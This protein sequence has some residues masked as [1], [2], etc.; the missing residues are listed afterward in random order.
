MQ[1]LEK[2]QIERW[3]MLMNDKPSQNWKDSVQS[4]IEFGKYL[5][6]RKAALSKEEYRAMLRADF[7][8]DKASGEKLSN[9][10]EHP[11]LSNPEY[12]DKLP[13]SWAQLYELR[14]LPDDVLLNAIKSGSLRHTTKYQI[15]ALRGVKINENRASNRV[16][17]D[18]NQELISYVR[19][20]IKLANYSSEESSN[21][22]LTQVADGLGVGHHSFRMLRNIIIVSDREDL[23]QEDRN[24]INDVIRKVNKTRNV[25]TYYPEIK[26]IIDKIWGSNR[27]HTLTDKNAKKRVETFQNGVLILCETCD[28]IMELDQPHMADADIDPLIDRLFEARKVIAQVAENLRRAKNE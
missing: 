10:A 25:R 2:R 13:I 7:G 5:A 17:V 9:I 4:I 11:I 15:W 3:I 27:N 1:Q 26:K 22:K 28:R 6:L 21:E 16:T 19:E 23:S 14:F 12:F 8:I 20:G 24:V 18:G